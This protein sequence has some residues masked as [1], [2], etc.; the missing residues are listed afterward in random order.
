[1]NMLHNP[2]DLLKMKLRAEFGGEIVRKDLTKKMGMQE[3]WGA[4]MTDIIRI[5]I[6]GGAGYVPVDEALMHLLYKTTYSGKKAGEKA[7]NN[8]G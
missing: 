3:N 1:M 7:M 8:G 5:I 4:S 6:K 2:R